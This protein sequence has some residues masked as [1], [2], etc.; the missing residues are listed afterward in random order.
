M[1]D[2]ENETNSS[3][4]EGDFSCQSVFYQQKIIYEKLTNA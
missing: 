1:T 2:L 3:K 4:I